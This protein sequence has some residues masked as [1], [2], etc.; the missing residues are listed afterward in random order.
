MSKKL[1]NKLN[2]DGEEYLIQASGAAY[3]DT[4]IE[5]TVKSGTSEWG[6]TSFGSEENPTAAIDISGGAATANPLMDGTATPGDANKFAR[7]NHVHPTDTTRAPND[8][9]DSSN[10]YG[11]A[12]TGK[13]G[14][15]K[16]ASAMP[17]TDNTTTKGTGGQIGDQVATFARADHIH[18]RHEHLYASSQS[19]G[20]PADSVKATHKIAYTKAAG[21]NDIPTANNFNKPYNGSSELVVTIPNAV[22]GTTLT[23]GFITGMN[24]KKLD[25]IEDGAEVNQSAFGIVKVGTTEIKADQKIDTLTLVA[26]DNVTI[27]PDATNDKVTIAT[28]TYTAE[29]GVTL[30]DY[31]IQADLK[32]YTKNAAASS[33]T[34]AA[35][36]NR[37]YPV[38]L[39]SAGDLAVSIP[40][41]D[42][43]VSEVG[44]HYVPVQS[45]TY[46]ANADS[47]STATWGSTDFVTG[48]TLNKDGAGHITGMSVSAK[49]FPANPNTAPTFSGTE[50]VEVAK[51]DASNN[52]LSIDANTVNGKVNY[53]AALRNYTPNSSASTKATSTNGGLYA[54]ELDKDGKLAVRVPWTDTDTKVTKADNH[55]DPTAS[56]GAQLS[57]DASSSTAATWN[58][59]SLVTGVN[60]QR[61]TKGHVTGV[62]VD[63]IKMPK[64]PNTDNAH[65]HSAG[66]GLSISGSGGLTGT[67]EYSLKTASSGEIGGVKTG[68]T[69]NNTNRNYAVQLDANNKA[70]VNVPWEAEQT[71]DVFY[72]A[73]DGIIISTNTQG[74]RSNPHLF[75]HADTS[76]VSTVTGSG[77]KTVNSVTF[78]GYGHVTGFSLR[79]MTKAATSTL[80]VA[81]LHGATD[82]TTYTSDDGGITP[83]AL[84][85]ALTGSANKDATTQNFIATATNT[86]VVKSATTGTTS[87]RDYNVQ[88]NTDGTMK[89]NVPWLAYT[90]GTGISLSGTTF[91]NS[92]VRS[93]TQDSSDGHKLS[94][95]TGGT[96]S[97]I[98]IPDNNTHNSHAIISGTNS[99]NTNITGSASSSNITLG[100]SGV[101]AGTYRRVTVNSKGIVIGGDNSDTDTH[102]TYA[103]TLQGNGT[104]ATTFSQSSAASL[105]IKPGSNVT[106]TAGTNEITI[107]ASDRNQKVKVG[108]STFG[109]SDTINFVGGTNISVTADTTNDKITIATTSTIEATT[110][111]ASSD[112]R[113]K[114][115][116]QP[117]TCTKSVLDLPIK[118]FDFIDGPK[119]QIGCI[120]Q[121]LL[122]ICPDLVS[123]NE[124]T[125]MLSIQESKLVYLLIEEVRKLK[126]AIKSN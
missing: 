122:E 34:S 38:Q 33:Q 114:E 16:S 57:A 92:G 48:V 121:D 39:D 119:N 47:S 95:N 104:T 14:H 117:Y 113:L 79:D 120:A 81:Y 106:V 63:S 1:H 40:W 87:G 93:I 124:Q 42:E 125:G 52:P 20:G 105:N 26:G 27:T 118:R 71:A 96:T 56:A 9:A 115:N 5:L 35:S 61:D 67:T 29:N 68:F 2:I 100:D 80:G 82:C 74:S 30:S 31:K 98:T 18:P 66:T 101:T 88:V 86:G 53:R 15:A 10:K 99:S 25:E 41:T 17:L 112:K 54:V 36:D 60:I 51:A 32:A 90:A 49:Q 94:I 28:A 73:G 107:A 8:H 83:L 55:Y 62:T 21:D 69:T 75:S 6:K 110:F 19:E 13:Y 37:L 70:Y 76:S 89:V 103:L 109:A 102:H 91:S 43:K 58:S 72:S 111:K 3:L 108:T 7:E 45:G 123:T 44:N 59:T 97:V 12:E 24:Q 77:I 64:N 84:R 22:G 65:A 23:A 126:K 11:L 50:G 78:D 4:D 116:I 85:K 46:T